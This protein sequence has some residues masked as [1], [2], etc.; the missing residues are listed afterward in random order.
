MTKRD[1]TIINNEYD[2]L[3]D[4]DYEKRW[5]FLKDK[6]RT[7][8]IGRQLTY[9]NFHEFL[10]NNIRTGNP[11]NK[12]LFG[13]VAEGFIRT[14]IILYAS[15]CETA[16]LD[17]I[18]W[19]HIR[20]GN[21]APACVRKLLTIKEQKKTKLSNNLFTFNDKDKGSV[22]GEIVFVWE[23]EKESNHEE[24]P[25][26]KLIEACQDLNVIGNELGKELHKLRHHR[27][28]IHGTMHIKRRR[29]S[30]VYQVS[31]RENAKCIT[32]VLRL[33]I[34]DWYKKP[35]TNEFPNI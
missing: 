9:L 28:T 7:Y 19:E 33:A 23:V 17:V 32:E 24:L 16:L 31:D 11:P 34:D 20:F 4:Y 12:I 30:Q 8:Y 6:D 18:W 21:I 25:F 13:N 22:T 15:I 26:E 29:K 35:E 27:N 2:F 3:T 10:F 14:D 5:G 1:V